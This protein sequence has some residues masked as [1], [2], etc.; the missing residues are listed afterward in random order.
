MFLPEA[1]KIVAFIGHLVTSLDSV[2]GTIGA[3]CLYGGKACLASDINSE[4]AFAL[5]RWGIKDK[6]LRFFS[7]LIRMFR[8]V[9]WIIA[10][11]TNESCDQ[12]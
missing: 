7:C 5:E 8:F 2:T 9:W 6:K 11:D 3:A 4:T 10:D 1:S 12:S